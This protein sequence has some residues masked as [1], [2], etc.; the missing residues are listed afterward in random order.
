MEKLSLS[1]ANELIKETTTAPH[2]VAHALAVS[3]AMGAMAE[4]FSEDVDYWQAVGMLHD[5]DYEQYPD[6]HLQHTSEPL[7]QAGIDDETIRTILSHGWELCSDVKPE[8]LIDKALYTVD[9]L[10]GLVSA[11]AK[12]RPN[13]ISDLEPKSV[14]K[15]FKDK[16]FAAGVDR[17]VINKGLEMLEM[18]RATAIEICINGMKPHA[19]ALGI[20]GTV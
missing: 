11:T 7:K 2:L 17:N 5:Y 8:K 1:K 4:H 9:A 3:V 14:V 16:G 10:T 6:E 18:D 19:K 12:M 13:G 20:E 15:K